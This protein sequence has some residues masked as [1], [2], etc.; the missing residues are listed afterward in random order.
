[1]K[2]ISLIS[3]FFLFIFAAIARPSLADVYCEG[4]RQS[5]SQIGRCDWVISG[6][7]GY[8]GQY[9]G[10]TASCACV[11]GVVA[12]GAC[13]CTDSNGGA[14]FIT[15][16]SGTGTG[17]ASG[18]CTAGGTDCSYCNQPGCG[19]GAYSGQGF[20]GCVP[21]SGTCSETGRDSVTLYC[22]SSGIGPTSPPNP[23]S[24]PPPPPTAVPSP[25]PTV[26]PLPTATPIPTATPLPTAT[27]TPTPAIVGII[28][29]DPNDILN[30]VAIGGSGMC[31]KTGPPAAT[32]L[33]PNASVRADNGVLVSNGVISG[34]NFNITSNLVGSA[35]NYTLSL[36]LPTPA[37]GETSFY[38]CSCPVNGNDYLCSYYNVSGNERTAT[39]FV[40]RNT[41]VESWWQT[42]GGN[43]YSKDAIETKIPVATCN[44]NPA[45]CQSALI[46]G[47]V[48]SAGFAVLGDGGVLKTDAEGSDAY[49]QSS[50]SRTT[51]IGAYAIGVDPGQ[52]DYAFF[53]NNVGSQITNAASLA[54]IKTGITAM[55]ADTI[56][57]YA[58]TGGGDLV[59]DKNIGSVPLSISGNKRVIIFVPGNL[60]FTNTS[61]NTTPKLTDVPV[62]SVL[63]FIVQGNIIVDSSV[64][65]TDTTTNPTTAQPNLTGIF[66]ADGQI[67]IQSDGNLAVADRKF[68]GAGTFVGWGGAG[69]G[70]TNGIDLRR[71]FQDATGL[72][73][74]ATNPAEA[75]VY[76]PDFLLNF[77]VELKTAYYNW[78]EIAPQR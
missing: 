47:S 17:T 39:F 50:G 46:V 57:F 12:D 74:N 43:V 40:K 78:A 58:Y 34:S 71:S 64:G 27:P 63:M 3:L 41:S 1:M 72:A 19:I 2:K 70:N 24:P 69:S 16:C 38:V 49:V 75:F 29:E 62:G 36:A 5:A 53:L 32:A 35:S 9:T 68:I 67:V 55:A 8:C 22:I 21:P 18:T 42:Y 77:P 54:E 11:Q 45:T 26:T 30:P 14:G 66:V 10:E 4:G 20:C 52:E 56:K 37:T 51:A 13:N 48:N 59:I 25:T 61:G 65:Y 44:L 60:S 15:G 33:V 23:T 31:V 73:K 76:R 28:Y 7:S 6:S